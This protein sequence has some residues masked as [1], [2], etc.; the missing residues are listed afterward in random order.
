MLLDSI[1]FVL[2]LYT[3]AHK[4]NHTSHY[5][6]FPFPPLKPT[7]S[8]TSMNIH[9]L[10]FK[11]LMNP[12]QDILV[13]NHGIVEQDYAQ[14]GGQC[15]RHYPKCSMIVRPCQ[16]SLSFLSLTSSLCHSL[17]NGCGIKCRIL[18]PRRRKGI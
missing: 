6:P 17:G 13:Q 12:I 11:A 16:V 5:S 1:P 2:F 4:H 10:L 3:D 18:T 8:N 9:I 15:N 14:Q 7:L